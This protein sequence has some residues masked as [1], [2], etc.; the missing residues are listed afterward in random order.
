MYS[1]FLP[2]LET[3]KHGIVDPYLLFNSLILWLKFL[4]WSL[5]SV[6]G[7]HHL[8]W[9]IGIV[10]ATDFRQ[11]YCQ[12]TRTAGCLLGQQRHTWIKPF[13]L[14]RLARQFSAL[15]TSEQV[16]HV[17]RRA[18][19]RVLCQRNVHRLREPGAAGSHRLARLVRNPIPHRVHSTLM[20]S[21]VHS[22]GQNKPGVDF[23]F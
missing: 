12:D 22:H 10:E 1:W 21:T 15:V 7:L 6:T 9:S 5:A 16:S 18:H 20:T 13:Q 14:T 19:S 3:H 4:P 11:Q 23:F 2:T 17:A 8:P